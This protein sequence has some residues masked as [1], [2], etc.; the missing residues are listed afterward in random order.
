MI[1]YRFLNR[2][3]FHT[4]YDCFISAYSDY[5]VPM[6][7]SEKQFEQKLIHENVKL[8]LSVG[9]FDDTEMVGFTING[10]R[11]WRG[12]LT[13]YDSGT[14]VVPKYRHRGIGKELF[15]FI[16]PHLIELGIKQ[17]LLEVI[18]S[19]LP[20]VNLYHKLGFQ[21]TRMLAVF[22]SNSLIKQP[23]K[24]SIAE[25]LE[26]RLPD[27]PLYESFW[28]T[29]PSWQNSIQS[30]GRIISERTLLGAYIKGECVGYGIVS[31]ASGNVLQLAVAKGHRR[32][33]IGSQILTA[34]QSKIIT[35]E[36]LKVNNVDHETK[37]T[38]A[39]FEANGFNI[40]LN[41]YEMIKRF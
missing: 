6:C 36:P 32:K 4:L 31:K 38:L 35:N 25:I 22:R 21:E 14:G 37:G 15:N 40:L 19:N 3:D 7:L 17:Y 28:D 5:I 12:Y 11:L 2:S 1:T 41:Q 20:A 26:I 27:W 23:N 33:R 9:A 30:V 39:F 29:D 13:A 24:T 34:L 18:T 10:Y 16:I 8:E